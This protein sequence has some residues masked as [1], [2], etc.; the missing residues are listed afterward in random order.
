[1][2]SLRLQCLACNVRLQRVL[3]FR[4]SFLSAFWIGHGSVKAAFPT[5]GA[6]HVFWSRFVVG[7]I[8]EVTGISSAADLACLADARS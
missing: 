1:M 4:V 3:S 7:I 2:Q 6:F 5:R 8:L